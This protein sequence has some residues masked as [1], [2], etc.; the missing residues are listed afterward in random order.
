MNDMQIS[1]GTLD[2]IISIFL[3]KMRLCAYV[4]MLNNDSN[5]VRLINF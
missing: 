2:R 3:I 1:A 5:V 4:Y